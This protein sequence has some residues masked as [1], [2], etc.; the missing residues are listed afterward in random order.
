MIVNIPL[1]LYNNIEEMNRLNRGEILN[2]DS[3]WT[4]NGFSLT[5]LKVVWSSE[6][7]ALYFMFMVSQ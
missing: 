1:A 4:T 3:F 2:D 5:R 7:A 6:Y